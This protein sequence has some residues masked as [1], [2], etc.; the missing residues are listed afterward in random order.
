MTYLYHMFY[1]WKNENE[2]ENIDEV[3]NKL[4]V[5]TE[6]EQLWGLITKKG[7]KEGGVGKV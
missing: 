6:F 7:G 5:K 4:I 3:N 2:N 1:I